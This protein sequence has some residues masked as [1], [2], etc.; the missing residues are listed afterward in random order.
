MKLYRVSTR[1]HGTHELFAAG[2]QKYV[3]SQVRAF[4]SHV[5]ALREYNALKRDLDGLPI[6][7]KLDV[8]QVPDRMTR[9]TWIQYIET[10]TIDYIVSEAARIE[11]LDG[12]Q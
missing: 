4:T 11:R 10:E 12:K 8:V 6:T 1:S 7:L 5:D 9:E 2:K 3:A